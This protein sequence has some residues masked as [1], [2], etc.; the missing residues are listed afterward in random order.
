MEKE[1]FE[2]I[3]RRLS[4]F[5]AIAGVLTILGFVFVLMMGAM[6]LG[7]DLP[8]DVKIFAVIISAL[9]SFIFF[10]ASTRLRR[11]MDNPKKLRLPTIFLLITSIIA[12]VPLFTGIFE[13][14][15]R[16][17][18]IIGP[19]SNLGYLVAVV[20]IFDC[21]RILRGIK[22]HLVAWSA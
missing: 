10:G 22:S 13:F 12:V 20:M 14:H 21:V 3:I 6:I 4:I 2:K 7:G 17:V 19:M 5:A 9:I 16:A 15:P 11:N 1:K 18:L 8:L